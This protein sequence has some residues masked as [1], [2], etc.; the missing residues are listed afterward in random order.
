[1]AKKIL[2][3]IITLLIVV[4]CVAALSAFEAHVINVTAHI[5]NA[6]RVSDEELD[7]GTVFP[8]EYLEREFTISL[9]SSFLSANR[10]DDVDYIIAQKPRCKDWSDDEPPICLEYCESLCKFLSKLNIEEDEDEGIN[11]NDID[12]KSYYQE[13]GIGVCTPP[14]KPCCIR[15]QEA[16]G[17]LAKSEEDTEDRWVV[18]L[19]VPPIEGFVGQDWPEDCPT[20]EAEASYC[21]ELWVEVTGISRIQPFLSEYI[22]GSSNNKALEI[23]NPSGSNIDL[24]GYKIEQYFNGSSIPS[25]IITIPSVSLASDDVYVVCRYDAHPEVLAVCDLQSGVSLFNGNDAVVLKNSSGEILDVIGEIGYDPETYWGS[26]PVTTQNHTLVRKCEISGDT[27]GFDFFD[28]AI[29]WD[30]FAQDD[31]SHLGS[32]TY[33]CP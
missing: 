29:E 12:A 16:S 20:I 7:F 11:E 5:E 10:V 22:E 26:E 2:L 28:P 23:Y 3:I 30:G 17:R 24:T 1:M 19:K 15:P 4:G 9:S 13:G 32:H 25:N 6:L 8:Q 18:D 14:D 21:C 33:F 27:N 31:F